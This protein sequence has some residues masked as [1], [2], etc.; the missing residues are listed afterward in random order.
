MPI[1]ADWCWLMLLDSA[2]CCSYLIFVITGTTGSACGEKN[3]SCGEISTL[4]PS[5]NVTCTHEEELGILVVGWC[6]LMLINS[7]WC[8]LILIKADWFW[9]LLIDADWCWLMLILVNLVI[10]VL[11]EILAS[12]GNLVILVCESCDP[13][14]SGE[15][16]FNFENILSNGYPKKC[17]V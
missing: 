10:L 6:C 16:G 17:E 14:H 13:G 4:W 15:F 7:D 8:W 1:D 3:L 11:L 12:L 5:H 2:W 9:L